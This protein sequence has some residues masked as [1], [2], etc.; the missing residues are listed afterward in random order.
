LDID[1]D[2]DTRQFAARTIAPVAVMPQQSVTVMASDPNLPTIPKAN[3]PFITQSVIGLIRSSKFSSLASQ[4]RN[5]CC[6]K[7]RMKLYTNKIMDE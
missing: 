2:V 6:N 7:G 4:Q 3:S 5:Y 1:R